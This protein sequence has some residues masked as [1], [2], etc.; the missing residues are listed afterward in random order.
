MDLFCRMKT[1]LAPVDFSN[2]TP[3]VVAQAAALAKALSGRVVLMTVIQ[4]PVIIAEYGALLENIAEITEAGEA[5]GAPAAAIGAAWHPDQGMAGDGL[6]GH[7]DHREGGGGEGQSYCD[8]VARAHG[9]LRFAGGQHDARRA[10][11]RDV[12]GDCGAA[13]PHQNRREKIAVTSEGDGGFLTT[14]P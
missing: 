5:S 6:G 10:P 12:S 2:A 8:R 4:P 3:A 14:L 13:G 11:P 1:I 7:V 9:V